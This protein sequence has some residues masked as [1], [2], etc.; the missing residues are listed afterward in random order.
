MG[1]KITTEVR[2]GPSVDPAEPFHVLVPRR[3]GI[4]AEVEH[5]GGTFFVLTNDDALAFR[6]AS[7]SSAHRDLDA[8]P[9]PAAWVA[10]VP[11]RSEERRVGKQCVS[12]CSTR[13]SPFHQQK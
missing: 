2:V 13:W 5:V 4:E 8:G 1:S 3:Q 9:A 10:V 7:M 12:T 11:H 6:V